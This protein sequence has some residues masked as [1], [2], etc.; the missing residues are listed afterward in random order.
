[1]NCIPKTSLL[2]AA[3]FASL[4]AASP[5][6]AAADDASQWIV[7]P[8]VA[9]GPQVSTRVSVSNHGALPVDVQVTFIAATSG[10]GP[11]PTQRCAVLTVAPFADGTLDL[12]TDCSLGAANTEGAL[13]LQPRQRGVLERLGATADIAY[14]DSGGQV[15]QEVAVDGVPMAGLPTL[16]RRQTID[17]LRHGAGL[18]TDCSIA[19]GLDGGGTA[20]FIGA[21][22]LR[23]DAG[24][25]IGSD[26]YFNARPMSVR[27]IEDVFAKA[28][29]T[30]QL[31]QG[32]R[33]DIDLAGADDQALAS[34]R[35]K[36]DRG[37][38]RSPG[39]SHHVALPQEPT[40]AARNRSVS[41]TSDIA[42]SQF[43]VTGTESNAHPFFVRHPDRIQ[44]SATVTGTNSSAQLKVALRDPDRM[45][46]VDNGTADTGIVD[47]ANK[48]QVGEGVS[49]AWVL[50]VEQV[51]PDPT[52]TIPYRVACTSGNGTTPLDYVFPFPTR[53]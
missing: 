7:V 20:G 3:A 37:P 10:T 15:E 41:A 29:V 43:T 38:A 16:N 8:F 5:A 35:L 26:V 6:S 36:R 9:S 21:I 34:C 42:R 47:T 4:C 1:M 48:S 46:V 49:R 25:Q 12:A 17:G 28:G 27:I 33:A 23:D 44:C 52:V 19:S 51:T 18:V 31:L 11:S 39:M 53:P 45:F 2:T 13:H 24:A 32:V 40:A 30:A 50:H 14:K 22:R